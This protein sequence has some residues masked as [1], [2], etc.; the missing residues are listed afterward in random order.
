MMRLVLFAVYIALT[1][2]IPT[3]SYDKKTGYGH[4]YVINNDIYVIV[5]DN[6][7]N[8]EIVQ[9]QYSFIAEIWFPLHFLPDNN[10]I[11]TQ[12]FKK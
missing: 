8:N 11:I 7:H 2:A 4:G 5:W 1:V 9:L 3:S 12:K 6:Y 10:K